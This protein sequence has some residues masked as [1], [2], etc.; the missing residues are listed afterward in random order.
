MNT[1]EAM[2][3][4]DHRTLGAIEPPEAAGLQREAPRVL[5]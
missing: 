3:R 1:Q 2:Q 4:C 5:P